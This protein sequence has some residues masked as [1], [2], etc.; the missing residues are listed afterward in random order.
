[1]K[2]LKGR[3]LLLTGAS[4]GLGEEPARAFARAGVHLALSGRNEAALS[5]LAVELRALGV[6]AEPVVADLSDLAQAEALF[7]RAERAVGPI[8][9]LVNNAGL[10]P[11]LSSTTRGERRRRRS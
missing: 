10:G 9:L 1:M 11:R 3:T 5:A 2:G 8:D 4:G 6:R 7:G